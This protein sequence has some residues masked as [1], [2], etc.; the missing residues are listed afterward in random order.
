MHSQFL[1][2]PP[3][4]LDKVVTDI[5]LMNL[6]SVFNQLIFLLSW[7]R[8]DWKCFLLPWRLQHFIFYLYPPPLL[9]SIH[10]RKTWFLLTRV[11]LNVSHVL[12]PHESFYVFVLQTCCLWGNSSQKLSFPHKLNNI[13]SSVRSVIHAVGSDSQPSPFERRPAATGS[14]I[15]SACP[16]FMP[17]WSDT[18]FSHG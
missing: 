17:W 2:H 1:W 16:K 12:L 11:L 10:R 5:Q 7:H 9:L 18:W 3:P 6:P 15:L 14:T 8:V 4:P 13:I